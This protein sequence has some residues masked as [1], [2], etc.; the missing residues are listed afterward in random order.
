MGKDRDACLY[1]DYGSAPE[2]DEDSITLKQGLKE[3]PG[4]WGATDEALLAGLYKAFARI[5]GYAGS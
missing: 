2:E 3:F 5:D 4:F 1:V